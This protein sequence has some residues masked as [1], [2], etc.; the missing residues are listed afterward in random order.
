M[1]PLLQL[2]PLTIERNTTYLPLT[3]LPV[4]LNSHESILP[5]PAPLKSALVPCI[6]SHLMGTCSLPPH[7]V[8]DISFL[9]IKNPTWVFPVMKVETGEI[10]SRVFMRLRPCEP[11]SYLTFPAI[12]KKKK[13]IQLIRFGMPEY[14]SVKQPKSLDSKYP[15]LCRLVLLVEDSVV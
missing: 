3:S 8:F 13:F 7:L 12:P 5:P 4:F 10:S 14:L 2:Q 11:Q 9:K 1:P 6:Q 15:Q